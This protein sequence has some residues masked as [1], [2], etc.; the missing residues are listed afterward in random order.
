MPV[1]VSRFS[2]FK[3]TFSY[4]RTFDFRSIH[5]CIFGEVFFGSFRGLWIPSAGITLDSS[6]FEPS[7]KVLEEPIVNL[8]FPAC[9]WRFR[10]RFRCFVCLWFRFPLL[11]SNCDFFLKITTN[12]IIGINFFFRYVEFSGFL[13]DW[14][15][16]QVFQDQDSPL[17]VFSFGCRGST[18]T[19]AGSPKIGVIRFKSQALAEFLEWR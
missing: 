13:L 17:K 15:F 9:L 6:T 12:G 18:S 19:D 8:S 3:T 14:I 4:C 5:A 1:L 2:L 10:V 7:Y 11:F 16:R